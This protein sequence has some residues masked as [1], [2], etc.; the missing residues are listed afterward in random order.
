MKSVLIIQTLLLF[1]IGCSEKPSHPNIIIIFT[2]DQGYGDLGCYGAKGFEGEDLIATID[3]GKEQIINHV[4]VRF[5]QD[6]VVWI[7]LPKM[8]QIEHSIDGINFE[9]A[10]EFYPDNSFSYDQ[11]IFEYSVKLNNIK[12]RY[13]RVKGLNINECP[14]FHPGAGGPSWVFADEIII[15]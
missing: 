11:D 13:V 10:Y 2:D 7:F 5:L 14:D 3:L 8:I 4:K 15:K 9:L 1:L 6:Q 12:S